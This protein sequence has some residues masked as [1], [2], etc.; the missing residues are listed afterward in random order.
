MGRKTKK[1]FGARM[2]TLVIA[3]ML[4]SFLFII[5]EYSLI[6]YQIGLFLLIVAALSQMAFGNIPSEASFGEV[7]KTLAVAFGI[8]FCVFGLGILLAPVLVKIGR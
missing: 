3:T 7:K 1:P 4:L 5:Q 6:V 8:V 2:Q